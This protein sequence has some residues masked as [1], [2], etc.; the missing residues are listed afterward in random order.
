MN[1]MVSRR[2]PN[3][4]VRLGNMRYQWVGARPGRGSIAGRVQVGQEHGPKAAGRG[5]RTRG[6]VSR[7]RTPIRGCQA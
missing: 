7:T 4:R 3:S 6:S 1:P 2:T 5:K